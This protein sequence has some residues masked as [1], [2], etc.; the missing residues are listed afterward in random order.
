MR[1]VDDY[2]DAVRS[3][4][5][6]L[7]KLLVTRR[8]SQ[9]LEEYSQFNDG[10][11]ALMQIDAEGFDV[12]PGEAVRYVIQDCRSRDPRRRV[13]VDPFISG[14]EEYDVEAY[15]ELLMRGVEGLLLPFGYDVEKL[16]EKYGFR[17]PR[18]R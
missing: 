11:A 6:P 3:Q 1:I 5:V 7:E 10:I 4:T 17:G 18:K 9:K 16:R 15:L 13:K 2:V 14:S 8:I 12:N